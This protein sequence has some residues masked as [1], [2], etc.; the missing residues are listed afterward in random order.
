MNPRLLHKGQ[1]NIKNNG[2]I[3]YEAQT[4]QWINNLKKNCNNVQNSKDGDT[5]CLK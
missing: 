4:I 2:R 5:L 3:L 1:I